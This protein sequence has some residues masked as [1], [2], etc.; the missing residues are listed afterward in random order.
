MISTADSLFY[1]SPPPAVSDIDLGPAVDVFIPAQLDILYQPAPLTGEVRYRVLHGGRGGTKSWGIAD[2]LLI[3]GARQKL[4][5]GC[6]REFQSSLSESVHALLKSRIKALKLEGVYTVTKTS[7]IGRTGTEFIFRGLR[8][9]LESIRSLEGIDIAWIEE[10][11]SVSS[12][13]W[14][15]LIPTIR[16]PNSEIWISFNPDLEDDPTYQRFVVKPPSR[17]IVREVGY[18]DNPFLPE[19]LAHE[20]AEMQRRDPDGFAHVWGGK[21]WRSSAAEV[22]HGKWEVLDF[23]VPESEAKREADG[24]DDPLF[25]GDFGFSVDPAQGVKLWRKDSRLYIEHEAGGLEL[26]A[27]NLFRVWSAIPEALDYTWRCDEARPETISALKDLGLKAIG[28]PKW[29]GSVKDGIFH[30]R[31]YE[32]ILIHPRCARAIQEAR[33]Y[34]YKIDARTNDILPHLIDAH[35]H[36]WDAARYALAPIIKAGRR[37]RFSAATDDDSGSEEAA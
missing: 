34:R 18:W 29:A 26:S 33:L 25:G 22:L 6:F 24:W 27:E 1:G 3:H 9:N 20:A 5:I 30:L 19:V 32:K 13:S 37:I 15:V 10:A 35:N 16:T 28:A 21:T 14:D 12:D 31:S 11:H 2:A 8:H 17:A 4:R 7:I 36:T 23:V